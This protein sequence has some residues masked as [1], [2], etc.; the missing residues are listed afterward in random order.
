MHGVIADDLGGSRHQ[1][2]S[3]VNDL[4]KG[5]HTSTN[6]K[7]SNRRDDSARR[8]EREP[9]HYVAQARLVVV[10]ECAQAVEEQEHSHH[11]VFQLLPGD[12]GHAAAPAHLQHL[13]AAGHLRRLA[14]LC[15]EPLQF[16]KHLKRL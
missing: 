15:A 1:P 13:L 9:Y 8:S 16:G 12:G 6:K 4:A 7:T 10:G 2:S 11:L 14:A 3:G 5:T